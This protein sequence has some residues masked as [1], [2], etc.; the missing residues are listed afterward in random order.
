MCY[1]GNATVVVVMILFM[2][3]LLFM[4]LYFHHL[5]KKLDAICERVECVE[6]E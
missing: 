4:T 2:F 1:T 5:D 3:L 6:V